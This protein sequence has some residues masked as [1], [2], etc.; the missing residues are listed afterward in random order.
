MR[1]CRDRRPRV[2]HSRRDLS[3]PE[4]RPFTGAHIKS[5]EDPARVPVVPE[6]IFSSS[7]GRALASIP[8]TTAPAKLHGL[9]FFP[10]TMPRNTS[11][12]PARSP[13]CPS[14]RPGT[15]PSIRVAR[16]A[17]HFPNPSDRICVALS[18]RKPT[19]HPERPRSLCRQVLSF[20]PLGN[21]PRGSPPPLA[22]SCAFAR[23]P[24]PKSSNVSPTNETQVHESNERNISEYPD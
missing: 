14:A 11:F 6:P 17:C 4:Q 24:I 8:M 18:H 5:S 22:P 9:K 3:T 21:C 19:S 20:N 2:Q 12:A 16:E 13:T 23:R 1:V 10:E 15:T 7:T